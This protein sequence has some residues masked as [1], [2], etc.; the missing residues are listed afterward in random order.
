MEQPLPAQAEARAQEQQPGEEGAAALLALL[1]AIRPD[2][3][4]ALGG[5]RSAQSLPLPASWPPAPAPQ[6]AASPA[7][8][9]QDLQR[10]RLLLLQQQQHVASVAAA[11]QAAP[12]LPPSPPPEPLAHQQADEQRG[13]QPY[14]PPALGGLASGPPSPGLPFVCSIPEPEPV[15]TREQAAFWEAACR[16]R[17]VAFSYGPEEQPGAQLLPQHLMHALCVP[18]PQPAVPS[19]EVSRAC[20][21]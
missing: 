4:A 11:Q 3:A 5:L 19:F 21:W 18:Q 1:L 16:A 15:L 9:L 13:W 12:C 8:P 20:K 6:Q 17:G 10:L 2:A 14:S 7:E